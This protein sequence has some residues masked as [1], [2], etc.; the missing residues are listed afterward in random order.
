MT[1]APAPLITPEEKIYRQRVFAWTMYDWANSAFATTILAAVLPVYFS[2]VAAATLPSE[3][4]ATAYWSLGLSISLFIGAILAPLLGTISDVSRSKKRLLGIF[5]VIGVVPTGLLVLIERGDWILA[6][7]LFIIAR[8]GFLG[9]YSFYDALLPHVAKPADQ[10]RVSARGY[11]M[12]YLGGGILLAVNIVMLQVF[13]G[14]LGARLSFLSVAIWWAVFSIPL[15]RRVPEPGK[16]VPLPPGE[17]VLSASWKQLVGTFREARKYRELFK[18]LIAFL[19]YNDA[20]GTIIGLA[21]IYGAELGFGATELIL[22]LLLV[23]F[24]GIP[25]SLMFGRLPSPASTR[26]AFYLAFVIFNLVAL[27]LVGLVGGQVLPA[28]LIGAQP[29]PYEGDDV[30]LGQGNYPAGDA[31]VAYTGTWQ[32]QL[33]SASEAGLDADFMQWIAP[34]DAADTPTLSYTF[35]GLTS[36]ILYTVGPDM[37]GQWAVLLDGVPALDE[38]GEPL[39]IDVAN[40]VRRFN[41]TVDV[42]AAEAGRHVVTLS[43]ATPGSAFRLDGVRVAE[44]E[45]ESS[46]VSILGILLGLQVI[47]LGFAFVTQRFFAPLAATLDTRRSILLSLV[48]Y[49]AVAMMG[50][51]LNSSI[52]FWFLAW[53]VAIVQGGSQALSRSLYASLSPAKKSGEFFGL[54]GIMEKF[55]SILGPLVF[56]VAIAIFGSSRPAIVS[57]IVFFIVGGFLLTRVNIVE[58]QRVAREEDARD[59]AVAA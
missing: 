58:G 30:A 33:V 44:P 54:Y 23:Q 7:G 14:T 55:S 57:L 47:G 15:F 48:M 43:P 36:S 38:D 35:N 6:L 28:A 32:E 41:E 46:L 22:A 9:A 16:T 26:R 12:G 56:A 50:F 18:Y 19:I 29:P 31:R 10:D 20:I 24:V 37:T 51:V 59:Q 21:A 39:L 5:T 11:A 8:V 42:T 3:A 53:M 4:R 2:A 40:D 13:P 27:P 52:E 25:F 1:T 17:T 49:S 45:R 34:E